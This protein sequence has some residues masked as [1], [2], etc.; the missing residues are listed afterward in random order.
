MSKHVLGVW[1]LPTPPSFFP[2]LCFLIGGGGLLNPSFHHCW[3]RGFE[4]Y[5]TG[6]TNWYHY[7]HYM[8]LCDYYLGP[9]FFQE[10]LFLKHTYM[11]IYL[12][13]Q[14]GL[15]QFAPPLISSRWRMMLWVQDPSAVGVTS[16]CVCVLVCKCIFF[17]SLRLSQ[18]EFKWVHSFSDGI[19]LNPSNSLL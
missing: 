10:N 17:L 9:Y 13:I 7:H 15:A 19:Y 12:F 4:Y 11:C 6:E 1:P 14:W 5:Y 2:P 16:Q 18:Y 8:L 3:F